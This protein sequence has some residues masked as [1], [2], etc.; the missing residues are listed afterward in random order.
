MSALPA[1]ISRGKNRMLSP[2]VKIRKY[3]PAQPLTAPSAAHYDGPITARLSPV[4]DS[5]LA[6]CR[7]YFRFNGLK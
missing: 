6:P 2:C 3:F 5:L 1:G 7:L 4:P